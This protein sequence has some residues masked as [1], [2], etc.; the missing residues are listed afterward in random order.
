MKRHVAGAVLMIG[1]II[2]ASVIWEALLG[3]PINPAVSFLSE[4]A[5]KDQPEGWIF[6]LTD[7]ISGGLIVIGT[8]LVM[9]G[10]P[11]WGRLQWILAGSLL[12]T[13]I[14]TVAD[15]ASPMDCAESVPQCHERVVQGTVSIFHHLHLA[16]STVAATGIVIGAL[17]FLAILAHRRDLV[18]RLEAVTATAA[19]AIIFCLSAQ[20]LLTL[21]NMPQGWAQRIQVLATAT[22]ICACAHILSRRVDFPHDHT[23]CSL[24]AP[25][26]P[27]G[28]P[29]GLRGPRPS[30]SGEGVELVGSSGHPSRR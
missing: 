7:A 15:A 20:G 6:R 30:A 8:A 12:L 9:A 22:F 11:R 1:G 18:T 13:G 21:A 23:E 25:S 2:Y 3:Y 17:A 24:G 5:A 14:G 26:R 19:V 27:G 28:H 29:A 16:T 10:R 4:L